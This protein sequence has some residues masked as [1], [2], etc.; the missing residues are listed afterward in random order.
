MRLGGCHLAPMLMRNQV[1]T[2]LLLSHSP[3]PASNTFDSC[4][5]DH[6]DSLQRQLSVART[7]LL[8]A[9][10]LLDNYLTSDDQLSVSSQYLSGSTIGAH[11]PRCI[12]NYQSHVCQVNICAMPGTTLS[13]W[14][15]VCRS[16]PRIFYRMILA[17][18][19][20]QWKLAVQARRKP[21]STQ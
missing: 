6:D 18:G 17:S 5:N 2:R 19:I 14:R 9:V 15:L 7:V 13:Y 20:L 12:E 11:Q 16:L 21:Y 3:M 4:L 8:Q 1:A 10:D